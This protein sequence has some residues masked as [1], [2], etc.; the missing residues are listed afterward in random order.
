M[1]ANALKQADIPE[2]AMLLENRSFTTHENAVYT[3]EKLKQRDI[4]RITMNANVFARGRDGWLYYNG[5][6]GCIVVEKSHGQVSN[7]SVYSQC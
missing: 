4:R 2:T 7:H 5:A 6:Y 3:A 1:M